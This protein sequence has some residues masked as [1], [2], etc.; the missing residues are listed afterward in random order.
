MRFPSRGG[1]E[2]ASS[3]ESIGGAG[4]YTPMMIEA[5]AAALPAIAAELPE[6]EDTVSRW[7][8]LGDDLRFFLL[9]Y[10]AGL[11]VFLVMLS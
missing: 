2:E 5:P 1:T 3:M 9:C 7:A 10:L 4:G 11:V 8:S 6:D